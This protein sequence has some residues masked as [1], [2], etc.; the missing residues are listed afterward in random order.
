MQENSLK[1]SNKQSKS[2]NYM[3]SDML[4]CDLDL[5]ISEKSSNFADNF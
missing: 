3:K 2:G 4:F 5:H 1:I